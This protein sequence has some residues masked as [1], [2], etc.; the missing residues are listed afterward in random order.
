MEAPDA[1]F[2]AEAARKQAKYARERQAASKRVQAFY[3]NKFAEHL[4]GTK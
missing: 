1:A 3:G 4:A 2:V